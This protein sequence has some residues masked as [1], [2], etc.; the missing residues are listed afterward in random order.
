MVG[1]IAVDRIITER[2]SRVQLGGPPTYASATARLLGLRIDAVTKIGGDL[3]W[4][5]RARLRMLGLKPIIVEGCETTRFVLD[6]RGG[7]RRLSVEAVCEAIKPDEVED[8]SR[9]AVMLTPIIG[10]VPRETALRLRGAGILA[11]DP[12]GYLRTLNPDGSIGLRPW[13]DL[14]LLSAID[15]YKSTLRELRLI[16]GVEAPLKALGRLH[17]I[18]VGEAI[19]TLGD[20]GAIL[21]LGDEAYRIPAYRVEAVDPTGA[22]DVYLAAYL[23]ER[24]RGGEPT[25]CGAFASATASLIVETAGASFKASSK[26][27]QR[28][29]YEI[30]GEVK[31]LRG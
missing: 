23:I 27:L 1:H 14:E 8:A 10:E 6:Y 15:I 24:L 16:T 9:D 20:E 26:E 7:R 22:G 12:Q 19:A 13:L 30:Y 2:G 3:P 11:L 25:W 5:F 4:G 29:A 18:G 31:R 17:G 28:R 21:S